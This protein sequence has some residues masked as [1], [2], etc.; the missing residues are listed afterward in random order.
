MKQFYFLLFIIFLL[1]LFSNAQSNYQPGYVINV[2]GDT[3][4]GFIDYQEWMTNPSSV[5]FKLHIADKEI[6]KLT[7]DDIVF[8]NVNGFESYRKFT[9]KISMDLIDPEHISTGRDTTFKM[10]SVFLKVLAKGAYLTLFSY[11][12]DIR[13][14]FYIEQALDSSPVELHY[15]LYK[16]ETN[17]GVEKTVVDDGFKKQLYFIAIKYKVLSDDLQDDL[18]RAEYL[19]DDL[20][21]IVN[22]INGSPQESNAKT[23][24][25]FKKNNLFLGAGINITN[26]NPV[27]AFKL[28][29]PTSYTS[30]LPMISGGVNF[31]LNPNIGRT[32]LRLELSVGG[33]HYTT[34]Y[35]DKVYPYTNNVYKYTD[36][37]VALTPQIMY[38]FYNADNFKFFGGLGIPLVLNNYT[39]VLYAQ[40]NGSPVPGNSANTSDFVIFNTPLM[41]KTGVLINNKIEIYA[42]YLTSASVSNDEVFRLNFTSIQVG[43]NYYFR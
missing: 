11:V 31:P 21:K 41:I 1:P 23:T 14:H 29:G 6:K 13:P 36:I 38:R 8:F 16:D 39:D 4:R 5:S 37:T 2:K 32:L 24:A 43:M 22:K 19:A 12:D 15:S 42:D 40:K 26:T 25:G 20:V 7:T 3:L 33:I 27:N 34:N 9:G 10:A 28:L 17:Q 18:Q 30:F 35:D